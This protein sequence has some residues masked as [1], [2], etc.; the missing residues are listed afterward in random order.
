MTCVSSVRYQ[1]KFN[2]GLTDTFIPYC[3][4]RQGD[5]LS[6][7]LNILCE[8][9]L[10]QMTNAYQRENLF[11]IP[12][13]A[14]RGIHVPLLQFADDLL[15]FI[16]PTKKSILSPSNILQSLPKKMVKLVTSQRV[17]FFFSKSAS[18]SVIQSTKNFLWVSLPLILFNI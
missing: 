3:G 18:P 15:F 8:E 4:L 12:H 10:F 9:T 1:V 5:P 14:P 17:N 16:H 6:P 13:I 11:S 7:Y 2:G